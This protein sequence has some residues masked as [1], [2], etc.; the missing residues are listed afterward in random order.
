MQQTGSG[1]RRL[2]RVAE[3]AERLDCNPALVYRLIERGDLPALQLDGRNC[4]IRIDGAEFDA[5][6]YEQLKGREELRDPR[7]E[8][9]SMSP[10]RSPTALRRASGTLGTSRSVPERL[11]VCD[12]R[13]AGAF[14]DGDTTQRRL[15]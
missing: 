6:L 9:L 3:A 10:T 11:R 13:V 12:K 5:W 4:S 14:E 1:G 8:G 2:I 15:L 7:S